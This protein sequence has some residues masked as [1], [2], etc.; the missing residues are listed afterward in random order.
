MKQANRGLLRKHANSGGRASSHGN[1]FLFFLALW[2]TFFFALVKVFGSVG[3]SLARVATSCADVHTEVD[4]Q[5][6]LPRL[7][8]RFVY[9]E[10]IHVGFES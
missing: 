9:L 3:G 7:A 1:I 8:R 5:P 4:N 2:A 6:W 10:M